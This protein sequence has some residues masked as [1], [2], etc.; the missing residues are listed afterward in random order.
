MDY[1]KL[2]TNKIYKELKTDEKGLSNKE[3]KARLEKYGSNELKQ[4]KRISPWKIFF[5]QF[6]DPLIWILMVAAAI[7]FLLNEPVDAIVIGIIVILNA[8]IGFKQEYSAEKAIEAL[9]KMSSFHA[10]VMRDG[11]EIEID[12][13]DVVP[14][15][16]LV[17]KEGAK[18]PA[19]A[20]LI[21]V[22]NFYTLEAVLTG[23]SEPILK[24]T[25]MLSGN[26]E[27]GDQKNMVF[28]ST[29]ITKGKAL[30][31]VIKTGMETE[32][33]KIAQMLET[34]TKE[35]TPL[36]K[37][38]DKLGHFL[39][40]MTLAICFIIFIVGAVRNPEVLHTIKDF[41]FTFD[42]LLKFIFSIKESVLEAVALAVA[43][44]PEGLPAVVPIA[45]ALG[46]KR[47]L[48]RHA[49]IRRLPS[50]ETLG[51]TTVICSD[52]TGTLT[53]NEMTVKKV[54]VDNDIIDVTG[55]GYEPIGEFSKN[56]EDLELLMQ[57]GALNNDAKI[58]KKEDEWS[59]FGDPTEA[60]LLVS[61]RKHGIDEA[62]IERNLR[63]D[64]IPFDSSRKMMTTLHEIEG[65]KYVYV[66]GAPDILLSKCSKI[67]VKGDIKKISSTDKK[68][69]QKMNDDFSGDALRVLGFAYKEIKREKIEE[70]EED[71]VFVGL[72]GM[73]DPPRKEVKDS[74]EQCK[75]AGI[76]VVMITG[77]F[78]GT[79]KAIGKEL[80]ITGRA[81]MG[82]EL[83]KIDLDKEVEDI[84]IYARVNPEDKMMIVE[85]LQK[86]GHIV[87]MT[88]DGVNDAP[89]LKKSDI[90]ISMGI[91][92]TDVAKETSDM[93]LTDDNFT[94]I[95]SAVEEGRGVYDN[96]K[97]FFAFLISGNIGEVLIIFLAIIFGWPV[98]LT[99]T[100]LLLINLVTD[101]LPAVALGADPFEPNAMIRKPR[102]KDEPIHYGLNP[103]IIWY[104]IIMTTVVLSL[105]YY[106]LSTTNNVLKAQTVAFLAISMSEMYQAFASRSIRYPSFKVGL[107]KNKYLVK[108][109]LISV[110]VTVGTIYIPFMQDIFNTTPI[111]WLEFLGIVALSS[112]GFIYLEIAKGIKA[113]ASES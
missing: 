49:L 2:S 26:K 14:G 75:S 44:I 13:K 42:W 62:F 28:S 100:Q 69:I 101:G 37:K 78:I 66:K 3:A 6:A 87:A 50:V 97:K 10:Y 73:I 77:D 55:A 48:K 82:S 93:I 86:K 27:L 29:V 61:A 33:G 7:S 52:K 56:T 96:I 41:A 54:Y 19:D 9:K 103:F 25:D 64:E 45:L 91:T 53:H 70:W 36:Q 85:A 57:I 32:I 63:I 94:S 88:G 43:A 81:V 12:A 113:K 17:L 18:V 106:T 99:A 5:G 1:Y 89:A 60:A 108:A 47:M 71:L 74:I 4:K 35:L 11:K 58:E 107:F 38:M 102:K 39:S 24:N 46:V 15:D 23:E 80:G 110:L 111:P 21:K 8:I 30:A 105:F 31:V 98:P 51:S 65:R 90:G 59:V 76:K 84:G 104:P 79:A 40:K 20:R 16:I 83:E 109:V 92:G 67:I 22:N 112:I 72:Q 34:T 68:R 95:V